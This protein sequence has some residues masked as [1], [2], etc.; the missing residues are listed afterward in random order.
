VGRRYGDNK[1]WGVRFNGLYRDG[2]PPTENQSQELGNAAY[3]VPADHLRYR[4]SSR[5]P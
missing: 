2:N 5:L 1:E 4:P 3:A